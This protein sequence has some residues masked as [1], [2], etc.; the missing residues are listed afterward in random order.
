MVEPENRLVARTLERQWEEHLRAVERIEQEYQTWRQQHQ[1][2]MTADDQA[3]LL[4]LG[5]DLPKVWH[6]PT[7]THADRKQWLR[8]VIKEV[9]VDQRRARGRVWFQINWQTGACTEHWLTRGV[10]TYADYADLEQVQQRVRE[11]NRAQ[12]LDDEIATILNAEGFRTA[13]QRPFSG[14]LIWLLRKAW[15]IATVQVKRSATTPPRWADGTYSVEGAAAALGVFPGTIYHWLRTGRI[16]G[17]QLA[18]GM[19]WQITLTEEQIAAL[20]DY[21]ARVRRSKKEAL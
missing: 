8:L 21:V 20:R 11:L 4:A 19:P 3:A 10:R 16:E 9:V 7:T 5:S 18:K 6:A 14:K 17:Q 12:K 1:L 2:T 13:R 15:G